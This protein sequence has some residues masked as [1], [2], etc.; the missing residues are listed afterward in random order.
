MNI[1]RNKFRLLLCYLIFALLSVNQI[2]YC[3]TNNNYNGIWN[4]KNYCPYERVILENKK[5]EKEF[6]KNV[7]KCEQAQITITN[8]IISIL[9]RNSCYFNHDTICSNF[10]IKEDTITIKKL[11]TFKDDSNLYNSILFDMFSENTILS[12]YTIQDNVKSIYM[13]ISNCKLDWG[14]DKIFFVRINEMLVMYCGS[15]YLLLSRQK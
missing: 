11:E 6:N 10:T 9:P 13:N 8:N 4:V 2:G 1:K 12:N 3:Q 14:N 15:Y 7:K 5:E